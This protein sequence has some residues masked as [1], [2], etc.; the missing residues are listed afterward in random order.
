LT[1]KQIY[2]LGIGTSRREH[3]FIQIIVH[4][5]S[6]LWFVMRII[7]TDAILLLKEHPFSSQGMLAGI[8]WGTQYKIL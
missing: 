8:L 3:S 6:R 2:W 1:H 5:A 4:C 7:C